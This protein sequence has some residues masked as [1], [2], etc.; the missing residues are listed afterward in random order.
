MP[1]IEIKERK[2]YWKELDSLID[3]LRS[4][5]KDKQLG[6]LNYIIYTLVLSL[7]KPIS[8]YRIQNLIGMLECCKQ[9]VIARILR[10]YEERK[11]EENGDILSRP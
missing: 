6:H 8:Y 9:E 1:Y 11:I 7:L 10:P 2:K 3:K 4:I 5:P